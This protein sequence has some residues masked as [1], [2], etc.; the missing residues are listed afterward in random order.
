MSIRVRVDAYVCKPVT[1]VLQYV[2][3]VVLHAKLCY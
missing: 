3:V 1:V 2:K